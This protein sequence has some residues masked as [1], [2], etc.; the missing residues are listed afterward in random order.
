M[1]GIREET[2]AAF[3]REK[4]RLRFKSSFDE[5]E[6]I[7][8][9]YDFFESEGFVSARFSRALCRRITNL[10]WNWNSYLHNLIMPSPN[11]MVMITESQ[12]MD[13]DRRVQI[14]N[15]MNRI[16]AH[17]VRNSVIGLEPNDTQEAKFI[18]ESV[19]VW[20]DAV[21]PGLSDIMKHVLREWKGKADQPAK[22]ERGPRH[23]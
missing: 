20:K 4:K 11:S 3:E 18:D 2:R 14:L 23:P 1:S 9:L 17:A 6:E 16:V 5:I 15:L 7:F 10:F 8:F 12:M 21:Q 13:E 19:Q 22:V